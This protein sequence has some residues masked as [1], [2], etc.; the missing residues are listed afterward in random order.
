MPPIVQN[1]D[2]GSDGDNDDNDNHCD[3]DDTS[4]E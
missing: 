2:Y 4:K 3:D 1:E